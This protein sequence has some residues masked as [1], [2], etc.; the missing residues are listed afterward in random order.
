[1]LCPGPSRPPSGPSTPPPTLM[2]SR[3]TRYA[4]HQKTVCL[5]ARRCFDGPPTPQVNCADPSALSKS[6]TEIVLTLHQFNQ[7]G[8]PAIQGSN[9]R[10]GPR[11]QNIVPTAKQ[12]FVSEKALFSL[13]ANGW[14][15]YGGDWNNRAPVDEGC[16]DGFFFFVAFE[17]MC[18]FLRMRVFVHVY[19][20]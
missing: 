1:M 6:K 10:S 15:S 9:T 13:R 17:C 2:S 8:L 5:F 12:F 16:D 18:T 4:P 14:L 20:V 7:E 3:L 19:R 11:T